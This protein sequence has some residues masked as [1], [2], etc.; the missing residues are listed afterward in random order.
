MNLRKAKNWSIV[1]RDIPTEGYY[2]AMYRENGS[3]ALILGMAAF[4]E[5][6][7]PFKVSGTL[8]IAWR[9]FDPPNT[10][11]YSQSL[12]DVVAWINVNME[13]TNTVK[14]REDIISE[15]NFVKAN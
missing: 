6:E 12:V 2:M 3:D 13:Y 5:P 15:L 4:G 1:G 10:D 14:L 8:D 11:D 7:D 9:I